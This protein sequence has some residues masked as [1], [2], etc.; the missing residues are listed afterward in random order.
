[1]YGHPF[2]RA[3]AS[4]KNIRATAK[5]TFPELY[6]IGSFYVTLMKIFIILVGLITIYLLI[7]VH[8]EFSGS[9]NYIAPLIVPLCLFRCAYW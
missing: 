6:M 1:M 7:I 9:M 5:H 3:S 2:C 4:I 8:S